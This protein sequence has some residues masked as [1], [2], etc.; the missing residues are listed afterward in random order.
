MENS[1]GV[2]ARSGEVAAP[3]VPGERVGMGR[4]LVVE[5]ESDLNDLIA[6]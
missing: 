4:I 3:P 2:P 1:R 6:R 5:D